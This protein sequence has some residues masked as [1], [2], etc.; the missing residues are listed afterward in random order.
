LRRRKARG[1]A[2]AAGLT[3]SASH[4]RITASP[5][6][7]AAP[8]ACG[9]CA[10]A[11]SPMIDMDWVRRRRDRNACPPD[12]PGKT[13]HHRGSR[14]LVH[15]AGKSP[16]ARRLMCKAGGRCFPIEP[17][18]PS[19]Y[20]VA[21]VSR[22]REARQRSRACFGHR[23]APRRVCWARNKRHRPRDRCQRL[24]RGHRNRRR[25][26]RRPRRAR[27]R[28]APPWVPTTPLRRLVPGQARPDRQQFRA[29]RP[30]QGTSS[31][32]RR[33]TGRNPATSRLSRRRRTRCRSRIR[34][35]KAP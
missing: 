15:V 18:A 3:R 30:R 10:W 21:G 17:S 31:P 11:A 22:C 32:P 34:Y 12:I 19:A 23:P 2:R 16:A 4:P 29:T 9:A 27:Q 8:A 24:P 26:L 33:S 1:T 14:V 6:R 7:R 20:A 5:P 25:P 28:P 13:R 35:G